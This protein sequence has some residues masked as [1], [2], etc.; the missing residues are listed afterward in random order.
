MTDT[1]TPATP[2]DDTAAVTAV[3][4]AYFGA[5]NEA[6]AG[7]RAELVAT[8]WAPDGRYVDPLLAA[9]GHEAI[10]DLTVQVQQQFPGFRFARTSGIDAHH[11]IV[12]F[13]WSLAGPDGTEA[14]GGL[15]VGVLADDGR[16]TRIAGFFG[17]LPDAA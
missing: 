8:A 2:T 12:R 6:D 7:R 14:V 4:D 16:L 11:G 9:E 15:D 17:P 5:L 3:I 13:A 1:T 10:G